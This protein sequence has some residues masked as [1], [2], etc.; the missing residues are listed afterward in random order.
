MTVTEEASALARMA[1]VRVQPD[2][3]VRRLI[4]AERSDLA[5]RDADAEIARQAARTSSK[6]TAFP[7]RKSSRIAASRPACPDR[8]PT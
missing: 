2:G 7:A 8:K 5:E 1:G 6:T 3:V 4:V